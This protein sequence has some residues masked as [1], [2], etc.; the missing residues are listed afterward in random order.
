MAGYDAVDRDR[1]ER[2]RLES[3]VRMVARQVLYREHPRRATQRHV[4]EVVAIVM[5]QL[6]PRERP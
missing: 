2:L 5:A 3:R 1:I 4:E 6:R